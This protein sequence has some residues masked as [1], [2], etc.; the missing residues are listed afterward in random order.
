MRTLYFK[1]TNFLAAYTAVNSMNKVK[2]LAEHFLAAYTAVNL[3][4]AHI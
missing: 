3:D 2:D 1:Q 4:L